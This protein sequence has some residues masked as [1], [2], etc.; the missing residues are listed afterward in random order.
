MS[1]QYI[2][3]SIQKYMFDDKCTRI[4]P[5]KSYFGNTTAVYYV[6]IQ[7][8]VQSDT[9]SLPNFSIYLFYCFKIATSSDGIY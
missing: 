5:D 6:L 8:L 2:Y 1:I 4:N 7:K 3:I 9:L